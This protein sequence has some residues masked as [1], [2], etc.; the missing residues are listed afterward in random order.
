MADEKTASTL[1]LVAIIL[2]LIMV[3]YWFYSTYTSYMGYLLLELVFPGLGLMMLV[4][5]I[6]YA[7]G[8][9]IGLIF[10]LLWFRWRSAPGLHKN[11]LILTGVLAIIF[12]GFLGGL[13]ALIA[14]IIAP[15]A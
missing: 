13:L 12:S 4:F 6:Y 8:G 2:Q 5:I 7:I 9:V 10:L 3:I 1:V 15:K 14:G 11:M